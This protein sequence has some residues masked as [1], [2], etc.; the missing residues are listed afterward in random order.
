MNKLYLTCYRLPVLT[1]FAKYSNSSLSRAIYI[2]IQTNSLF[3]KKIEHRQRP[4]VSIIYSSNLMIRFQSTQTDQVKSEKETTP[5]QNDDKK[6][7]KQSKFKQFY[8]QYGP[9]FLVVHLTTVVMWI[10]FFFLVSKQ[11]VHFF[12]ELLIKIDTICINF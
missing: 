11:Y 8:S 2:P 10:Y 3:C 7:K 6:P 4:P 9:L 12:D 5:T 1:N